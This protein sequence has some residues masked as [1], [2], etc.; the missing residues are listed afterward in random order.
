MPT[1]KNN[2][3]TAMLSMA[4]IGYEAEKKKIEEKIAEL[5]GHIAKRTVSPGAATTK[6]VGRPRKVAQEEGAE[7]TAAKRQRKPLSAAARKRIAIAQRKRW[8]EHRKRTAA[9]KE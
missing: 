5:R 1:G 4:L 3:D 2:Q 6:K 8:A 7:S 9:A